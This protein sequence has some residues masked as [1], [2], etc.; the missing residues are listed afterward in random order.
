MVDV[1]TLQSLKCQGCGGG[2]ICDIFARKIACEHCGTVE[3]VP[4]AGGATALGEEPLERLLELEQ[5]EPL[6]R[7]EGMRVIH[8]RSCGAEA[9]IAAQTRVVDCAFCASTAVHE[10]AGGG[11]WFRPAAL[12]PF[13]VRPEEA[14]SKLKAWARK[15]R[16][17]PNRVQRLDRPEELTAIYLPFWTFDA[18]AS[19]E[20]EGWRSGI[21]NADGETHSGRVAVDGR[22][23]AQYVDLLVCASQGVPLECVRGIEPFST[24]NELIAYDPRLLAGS[25]AELSSVGVAEAWRRAEE[26]LRTVE[27]DKACRD[28]RLRDDESVHLN[29]Q[30]KFEGRRG[31]PVLLPVY[32]ASYRYAGKTYRV[33]VNGET[34]RV[35]GQ[36]PYSWWKLAA[37]AVVVL[38][39]FGLLNLLFFGTPTYILVALCVALTIYERVRATLHKRKAVASAGVAYGPGANKDSAKPRSWRERRR[40]GKS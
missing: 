3:T 5:A 34:G 18:S 27:Y 25:S 36:A 30:Y 28:V 7:P 31:K 21:M 4:P 26:H 20:F 17:R 37:L 40:P 12:L 19:A 33:L 39:I 15:L 32:V 2:L 14:Q 1:Y 24:L 13:L 22:R 35:E 29:I 10:E 11:R 9:S 38:P 16:W 23:R 6:A 8:C